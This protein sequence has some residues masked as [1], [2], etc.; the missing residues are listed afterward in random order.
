[1]KKE[2]VNEMHSGQQRLQQ[3]S[4]MKNIAK[5]VVIEDNN[6]YTYGYNL[7]KGREKN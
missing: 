1:M 4:S 3:I 6:I 5:A 7:K 2:K